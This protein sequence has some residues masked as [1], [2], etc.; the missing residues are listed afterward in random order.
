MA[1]EGSAP[2]GSGVKK[3]TFLYAGDGKVPFLRRGA[4]GGWRCREGSVP[5]DGYGGVDQ[6]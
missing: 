4:A 3:G 6:G 2:H 1:A 5:E